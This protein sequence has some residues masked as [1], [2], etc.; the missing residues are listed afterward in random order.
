[1]KLSNIELETGGVVSDIRRLGVLDMG[2]NTIK[3]LVAEPVRIP[4]PGLDVIGMTIEECRVSKG[5]GTSDRLMLGED[6][7]SAAADAI[8]RLRLAAERYGADHLLA[9][10]TSAVRDAANRQA[11]LDRVKSQTG[12]VLRVLSG[13]EEAA[14]SAFGL[15]Y[16]PQMRMEN[17]ILHFDIGGGSLECNRIVDG[18]HVSGISLPLGAVRMT[19]KWI[20]DPMVPIPHEELSRIKAYTAGLLEDAGISG[21]PGIQ[22]V[23]TGGSVTIARAIVAEM[24]QRE[25]NIGV[26]SALQLN[27]LLK[28]LSSMP[29]TERCG[30]PGLPA[31]RADVAPAAIA[32]VLAVMKVLNV[33][34]L[35][36]SRYGLRHGLAAQVF[37]GD[38]SVV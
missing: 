9:V 12:V 8:D 33:D 4:R 31:N 7:M 36:H 2:S 23:F 35:V 30:V 27:H 37:F 22:L 26:L 25:D 32:V 18:R 6:S 10:A 14:A 34:H 24:E 16:D 21:A 20:C 15:A 5:I 1:M 17:D 19:E 38:R 13:A 3:L 11:F 28:M 29:F